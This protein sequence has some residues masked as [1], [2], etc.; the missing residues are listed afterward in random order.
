M[1]SWSRETIRRFDGIEKFVAQSD[2]DA[3]NT[4]FIQPVVGGWA[5]NFEHEIGLCRRKKDAKDIIE[6]SIQLKER[7]HEANTAKIK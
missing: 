2:T 4:G 1:I 5:W 3:N 7:K 6:N